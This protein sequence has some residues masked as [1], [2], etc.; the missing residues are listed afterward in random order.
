MDTRKEKSMIKRVFYKGKERFF[1]S[2]GKEI[3]LFDM[4]DTIANF[5]DEWLSVYNNHYQD[6]LKKE[7][8][9]SWDV[10]HYTK[11]YC[12]AQI[13]DLLKHPGLYLHYPKPFPGAVDVLQE[14]S[15]TYE[16]VLVSAS[17]RG[18]A[19]G[20]AH[21]HKYCKTSNPADDKRKWVEKYLPFVQQKNIVFTSSK[22]LV[23]GS[24][25]FDDAP[26]NLEEF[27]SLG[28]VT[29]CM[30]QPWNQE[31]SADITRV[32]NWQEFK[33]KLPV[34]LPPIPELIKR[35]TL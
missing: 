24:L 25:L 34:L 29:V 17:P 27:H 14:L 15:D 31:V 8:L 2:E 33:E 10:Q 30:N 16:I 13:Y 3:L 20:E 1:T 18:H 9:L 22:Y 12:G 32:N 6:N 23:T 5:V 7:Q 19:N 35:I 21:C 28:R 11:D 4:D 26:H